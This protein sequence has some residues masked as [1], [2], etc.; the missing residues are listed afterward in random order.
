MQ[1]KTLNRFDCIEA[2][3]KLSKEMKMNGNINF[4]KSRFKLIL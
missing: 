4:E 3:E 1:I 2:V